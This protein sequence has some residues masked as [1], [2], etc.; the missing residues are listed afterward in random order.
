M[1]YDPHHAHRYATLD[2]D[3][4]GVTIS[5]DLCRRCAASTRWQDE[6]DGRM[7]CPPVPL[8]EDYRCDGCNIHIHLSPM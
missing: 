3:E 5:V 7:F 4:E 1:N 8:E 6:I 2:I